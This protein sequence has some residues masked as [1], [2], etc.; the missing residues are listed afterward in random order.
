M[1]DFDGTW[2]DT[3]DEYL[4]A[5]LA[6]FFP[7]IHADIDW[8]QDY[9][10]LEQEFRPQAPRGPGGRLLCDKL[11]KA[12]SRRRA[13]PLHLHIEVQTY[14][15]PD[16]DWRVLL[17]NNRAQ[18]I[19]RGPV[20]SLV[21]LGDDSPTWR[22][23]GYRF[24]YFAYRKEEFVPHRKLLD[25]TGRDEELLGSENL[26]ALV[27]LAHLKALETRQIIRERQLWRLRLVRRLYERD[28]EHDDRRRLLGIV[29][30]ML[31]LP[32]D[33]EYETRQILIR[34]QEALVPRVTSFERFAR[35]EGLQEGRQEGEEFGL[36]RGLVALIEAR[37]GKPDPT[38]LALLEQAH[39]AALEQTLEAAKTAAS[40]DELRPLLASPGDGTAE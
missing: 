32:S 14:H 35:Q 19:C 11:I 30:G 39:L 38:F 18:E 23:S 15:D 33:L 21:V 29:E 25:W 37:F 10:S 36:R 5:F 6:F 7:E 12:V 40:I 4:S 16:L 26:V 28:L 17:Y 31:N 8:S 24:V 9:Q 2:K 3:L 22:P 34:E 1:S 20:V 13:D 27:V